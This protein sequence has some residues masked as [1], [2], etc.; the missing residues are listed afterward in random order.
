MLLVRLWDGFARL[1]A[2]LGGHAGPGSVLERDGLVASVVPERAG[3][4]GAERRR[5]A[6]SGGRA[7][8][9]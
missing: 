5:G 8:R 4:A 3:F 9:T 7:R 1:Q 6:R 2:L